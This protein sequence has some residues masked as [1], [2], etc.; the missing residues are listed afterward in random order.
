M[1]HCLTASLLV[2]LIVFSPRIFSDE[3]SYNTYGVTGLITTPTAR[4]P[5]DGDFGFGI[6]SE[7]PFNRLYGRAVF[8]PWLE[9]VVRYTEGTYKAYNPGSAQSWKDKGIDIKLRLFE[10][11][12]NIPSIALGINDF[13]GT[14]AY[15][16][17]YIVATKKL[18]SFDLSLGIGW[19][20]LG[21]R[22]HIDNPMGLISEKFKRRGGYSSFGGALNINNFFTGEKAAF[23]G[24]I[25]YFTPISNLSM[26]IEYD[27]SLYSDSLGARL[28]FD[29]P[30]EDMVIE[31][32]INLG[33]HY[34]L[35]IGTRDTIDFSL[36][37][38]RGN[39]VM[40]NITIHSNLNDFGPKKVI[41]GIEELKESV[42]EPYP[43]L[44]NEWKKY[45]KE[46]II[47]EMGNAGF[48][49]HKL[50]FNGDELQ[51]EISQGAWTD[52]L[53]AIDLASRI[54]A[55]NSPKNIKTITIINF[56]MGIESVRA[57]IPRR[58]LIE[59]VR[60]KPLDESLLT[61]NN[62]EPLESDAVQLNNE[63]L[64]PHIG[65]SIQPH[66]S[67]TLQ[68]QIQ[69]YFWQLEALLNA[70]ISFKKGLYL[71]TTYAI[72]I[73][74]NFENYT[75]HIPDGK[76]H[77]VRQDRRLYLTEG[78]S[79]L[80]QLTLDYLVNITPNIKAKMAM[81]YLE[82]M[83]GGLGGEIL[84]TP[85][86]R[87]WS[88]G[89]DGYW[90]KQRDF[91]QKLGFQDYETFTG[92]VNF[93]YNLP[94]YNLRFATSYG[95][96]LGK[97]KGFDI[98]ISRRFKTGARIGGRVALTDCDAACVGEGSFTKAIYF[99][100]PVDLFYQKSSQRGKSGYSWSPLT[101]DAGAKIATGGLY[102]LTTEMGNDLDT[103][104]TPQW[105]IKKILAG[106]STK[107]Q[108]K[109]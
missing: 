35:D 57:S 92:F 100:L 105:S 28:Y 52:P 40:A 13:G 20:S 9:G 26:K 68:H 93:Y 15:A 71:N 5:R 88:L 80:R 89:V 74:N 14:G 75:W 2:C 30:S 47:W 59:T 38:T 81:G 94:F 61:F 1:K 69:F 37:Y 21:D 98:D 104:K 109:I 78:E 3:P 51:A 102:E 82:W 29:K 106:F 53:H 23:F 4:I 76:L 91:D 24:G 11:T 7:L 84:Y 96:Y 46:T 39:T 49:V 54:I 36:G 41:M 43:D 45:L 72:N 103:L 10:E 31:S 34:A 87:R 67:G 83:Y 97:D 44:N 79:G 73:D 99:E 33:L 58:T 63:F 60:R 12:K 108:N 6:S 22:A 19:G 32:S 77:H 50:I 62:H 101:K 16:S 48:V 18:N 42:L 8:L 85:D 64:Y 17:E 95:K 66:M 65:W 107:P 86:H 25:E 70:N 90:V 55:N 56:D 27:P